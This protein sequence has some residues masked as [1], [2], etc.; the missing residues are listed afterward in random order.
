ALA[1][2][3]ADAMWRADRASAG[4]GMAVESVRPGAARLSMRVEPD[5]LNGYGTCHGGFI[6]A[7]ADSA[8][9][10][11]CNTDG[12]VSVAQHCMISYL[13]PVRAGE[14][15]VA[16][17]QERQR[18]GR[19]GIYDVRVTSGDAIVAEFRGFSRTT[20]EKLELGDAG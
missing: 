8:F 6:F 5:M 18:E 7:L 19:S 13:R 14:R 2:A 3:C 9:A 20:G 11:A 15:L 1:Q 16:D 17:A 4:L 12:M 10:F